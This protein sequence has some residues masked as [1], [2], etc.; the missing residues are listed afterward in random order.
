MRSGTKKKNE[1]KRN[2]AGLDMAQKALAEHEEIERRRYH[3]RLRAEKKGAPMEITQEDRERVAAMA[4]IDVT[5][6]QYL[7]LVRTNRCPSCEQIVTWES[8]E[9]HP[10][11]EAL[12]ALSGQEASEYLQWTSEHLP[13]C[14]FYPAYQALPELAA[15]YHI[16]VALKQVDIGTRPDGK[17][18]RDMFPVRVPAPGDPPVPGE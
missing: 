17:V 15:R 8:V 6:E 10:H 18:T 3:E 2:R 16:V 9:K 13:D 4:I 11:H 5:N 7:E 12:N 1:K 14:T